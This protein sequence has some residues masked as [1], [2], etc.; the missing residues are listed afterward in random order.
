MRPLSV[1]CGG[2]AGGEVRWAMFGGRVGVRPF[3]ERSHD[4]AFPSRGFCAGV[5]LE[6]HGVGCLSELSREHADE[7][8]G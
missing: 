4:G 8:R 6:H 3:G 2:E 5:D 1:V 7:A